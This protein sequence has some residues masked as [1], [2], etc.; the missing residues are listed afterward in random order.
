MPDCR[1]AVAAGLLAP[2]APLL[3]SEAGGER[4]PEEVGR[5]KRVDLHC[6]E[7]AVG[8]EPVPAGVST[9]PSCSR[10]PWQA[11]RL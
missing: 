1:N 11:E 3:G 9:C 4:W 2:G 5:L 10:S 6:K 7:A 8:S